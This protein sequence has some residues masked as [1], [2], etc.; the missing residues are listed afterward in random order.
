MESPCGSIVSGRRM[1][2]VLHNIKYLVVVYIDHSY[3]NHGENTD[4]LFFGGVDG[5]TGDEECTYVVPG[6][7]TYYIPVC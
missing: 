2:L 7:G 3:N 5:V 4:E 1:Y 6:P